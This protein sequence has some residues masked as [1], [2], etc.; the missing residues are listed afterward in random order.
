MPIRMPQTRAEEPGTAPPTD[1]AAG[2]RSLFARHLLRILPVVSCDDARVGGVVAARLATALARGGRTVTLVDATG[3]ACASAGA[4]GARDLAD[5]IHGRATFAQAALSPCAGLTCLRAR[6][7]LPELIAAGAAN[8]EFFAG[9]LRLEDPPDTLVLTLPQ[10]G[11]AGQAWLPG[12]GEALLVCASGE[13]GLTSAYAALKRFAAACPIDAAPVFRL[14]VNGAAGEREARVQARQ[15]SDTA[16]RFLG[17]AA[18]YGANLPRNALGQALGMSSG[19]TRHPEG[20]R[21]LTRLAGETAQWRLTECT[22]PEALTAL[23]H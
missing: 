23:A 19:A 1:Q 8:D 3:A 22:L 2:L 7:G 5:L 4:A 10:E 17:V 20:E 14:L 15:L 12:D 13:R 11:F 9:F 16:R 21:A 18:T 6:E